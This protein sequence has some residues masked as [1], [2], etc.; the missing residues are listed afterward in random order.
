MKNRGLGGHLL[1]CWEQGAP[2]TMSQASCMADSVRSM[3]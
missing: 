2:G 1:R 3:H